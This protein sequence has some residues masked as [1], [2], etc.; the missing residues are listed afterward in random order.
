MNQNELVFEFFRQFAAADPQRY[1]E[2]AEQYPILSANRI[3][4]L[5]RRELCV[6]LLGLQPCPLDS[7]TAFRNGLDLPIAEEE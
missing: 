6:G 2:L 1:Q 4:R 3:R 7:A 5:R